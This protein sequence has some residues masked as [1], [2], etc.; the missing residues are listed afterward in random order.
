ML[1]EFHFVVDSFQQEVNYNPWCSLSSDSVSV[2]QYVVTVAR[3]M[4]NY[5]AEWLAEDL[6]LCTSLATGNDP[7][8]TAGVLHA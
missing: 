6:L 5:E 8:L 2:Y 7:R 3:H 4:L 1:Q